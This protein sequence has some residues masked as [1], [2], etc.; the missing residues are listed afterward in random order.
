M[1]APA[2][3]RKSTISVTVKMP[4]GSGIWKKGP[5]QTFGPKTLTIK[6]CMSV[7]FKNTDIGMAHSVFGEKGEFASSMLA[8]GATHV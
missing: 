5:M 8:P 6:A 4:P 3:E 2:P 7:V 1:T